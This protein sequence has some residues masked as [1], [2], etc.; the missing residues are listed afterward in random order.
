MDLT[1]QH[2]DGK[3]GLDVLTPVINPLYEA[4]HAGKLS[5][6]FYSTERFEERTRGYMQAPGFGLVVASDDGQP[7]GQAFGYT[8]P[9]NARWWEGLTTPI[10]P[11]LISE[12][13]D[14]TFAVNEIM[15]VPEY[16]RKHV[17]RNTHNELLRVRKE[18]R[19]TLLVDEANTPA[20]TAYERWGYHKIG[21]L[22]PF[23]DSPNFA[24]MILPLP[25][26][27]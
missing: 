13:G 19:A 23:P 7:V 26:D 11:E 4:T 18:E 20:V 2:L 12:T 25:F 1:F 10:D 3:S 22:K 16:Q 21:N 9:P 27:E 6:P 14:R 8:L 5:D 15:V 17:A 24:A